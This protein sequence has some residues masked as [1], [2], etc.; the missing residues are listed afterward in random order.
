MYHSVVFNTELF[1]C[2]A[3]DLPPQILIYWAEVLR[4]H[5]AQR[6]L[7][8]PRLQTQVKVISQRLKALYHFMLF[9]NKRPFHFD[10]KVY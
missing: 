1:F 8:R 3:S 10:Y 9:F 6:R 4:I 2:F 7:Q 5:Q